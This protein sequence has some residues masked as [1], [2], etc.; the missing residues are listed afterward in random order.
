M[1]ESMLATLGPLAARRRDL[2]SLRKRN[3]PDRSHQGYAESRV[4]VDKRWQFLSK[5]GLERER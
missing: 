5:L 2:S 1:H 4:D 3:Q